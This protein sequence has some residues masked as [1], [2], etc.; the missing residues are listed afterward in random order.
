MAKKTKQEKI[1]FLGFDIIEDVKHYFDAEDPP[2]TSELF[3]LAYAHAVTIEDY[4][5]LRAELIAHPEKYK[6]LIPPTR[7]VPKTPEGRIEAYIDDIDWTIK[8]IK[9]PRLNSIMV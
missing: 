9:D 5:K 2:T 1:T 7:E 6:D 3:N 8:C 4:Q